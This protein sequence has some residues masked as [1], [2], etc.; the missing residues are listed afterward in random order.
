MDEF[1]Q[2]FNEVSLL[3]PTIGAVV[4]A[5]LAVLLLFLSGF[6]SGS[7]IAFFSL[8]PADLSELEED[9]WPSDRKI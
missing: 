7:E 9:K 4:A 3:T 8:S 2:I 6:A 1:L 5:V